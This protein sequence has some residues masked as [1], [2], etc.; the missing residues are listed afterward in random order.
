M[1]TT[2]LI[3]GA[4]GGIGKEMAMVAAKN[5]HDVILVARSETKLKALAESIRQEHGVQAFYY[6]ADLAL[7]GAAAKLY[8]QVKGDGHAVSYLVNNAGFGDYG[9]FAERELERISQMIQLNITALTELTHLFVQD[10]LQARKGGILNVASTAAMQPDP[11]LAVYGAS[12]SYVAN[13][14]EALWYELRGTGVTATVLSPG[15]TA[16]DFFDAAEMGAS[17]MTGAKMMPAHRVAEIGYQAMIKGKLHVVAGL[18]NKILSFASS[19]MP[20]GKLRL[21]IA[22]AILGKK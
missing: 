20:I 7:P 22:A 14:T 2:V 21:K 12:K 19:V 9:N 10:M 5:Q 3:T 6:T 15:G 4:S 13:F 8:Q 16:T 18:S 11:Y 1:K 17:K